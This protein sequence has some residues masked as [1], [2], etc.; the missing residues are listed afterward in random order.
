MKR[1]PE[2]EL[3][4]SKAQAAAYAETDFSEPH[5]AFVQH[6]QNR[7]PDF[8]E[9]TV[10]DLGCGTADVIIRFAQHYSSAHITGIDGSRAMLEIGRKDLS[11]RGFHNNVFLKQCRLTDEKLC[12]VK[13]NAVISNS[14]LHHL[15]DPSVLW[16]TVRT[17][18]LHSSPV[19]IMDLLRPDDENTARNL[20][21]EYASDAPAL[22]QE[23]FYSSL[24]AAYTLDEIKDQLTAAAMDYLT[25]EQISDRHGIVW[26]RLI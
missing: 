16:N 20:V 1:I 10:L 15:E 24:C 2:P 22:L 12:A 4:D 18:G 5:D 9:G 3:M 17:C 25:T 26:G 7:F 23:D 19:F 11:S 8:R 21:H 13:F 14:L 6:F